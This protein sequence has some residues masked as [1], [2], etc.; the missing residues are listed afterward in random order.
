MIAYF[1]G[2]ICAKNCCNRSVYVKIMASSKG[3]TFFETQ[4]ICSPGLGT[5]LN[6]PIK[7]NISAFFKLLKRFGYVDCVMTINV[8]INL[9]DHEL[10]KKRFLLQVILYI[11]TFRHI[12]QLICVY[13]VI[14]SNCLNIIL[15]G[16]R[17][18]SL[19]DLCMN[20]LSNTVLVLHCC[21][22][23]LF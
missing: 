20:I 4:C 5:V 14:L 17:N 13:V 16:I 18:R 15:L 1:L 21:F 7:N 10:F 9:S 3:G 11:T 22:F 2:N 6:C 23:L 12:V 19:F 8:L